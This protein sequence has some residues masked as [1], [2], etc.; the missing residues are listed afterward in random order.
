MSLLPKKGR[1]MLRRLGI[2]ETEGRADGNSAEIIVG[3]SGGAD[4]AAL[5][6]FL[7]VGVGHSPWLA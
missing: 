6:H 3:F 7:A 2:A 5:L 4:S 1:E